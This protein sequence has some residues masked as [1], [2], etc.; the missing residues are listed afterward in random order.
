MAT[1]DSAFR[2]ILAGTL[3]GGIAGVAL[4]LLMLI[5]STTVAA[6][7]WSRKSR[8]MRHRESLRGQIVENEESIHTQQLQSDDRVFELQSNE[9]YNSS[10]IHC[11]P[12][13]YNVAYGQTIPQIPAE[14]NVAIGV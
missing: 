13:E 9:A 3:G 1:N 7:C 12:T 2:R 11:I 5:L 6:V 14:D 8:I 10:A 4:L